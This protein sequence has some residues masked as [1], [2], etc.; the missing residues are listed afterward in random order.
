MQLCG[1]EERIPLVTGAQGSFE[2]IRP[3]I[4][5][6][7]FDG[8]EAVDFII[9][10]AMRDREHELI[11]LP[12]GKLTN[13]ALALLKEPRIAEKVRIVWLGS[14]YP[15]PGEHNQDWDIPSMNYILDVDVPFEMVTVRYGDPS[16]TDAVKVTQAQMLRRMPGKGPQAENPVTGRHGGTFSCWGDYSADL[17]SKYGM[18]GNPPARALFDLAAIA[19]VKNPAWAEHYE[20]PAPVFQDGQWAERPENLRK[21]VIWEWFDIYGIINDYFVTME[22]YV[23]ADRPAP[24]NQKD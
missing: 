6:P 2:E 19:I 3:F 21:I 10:Q 13:I 22:N 5:E 23:L 18:W 16:G 9:E 11:L 8:H 15:E 12:V 17:F 1:A 24:D 7:D 14:N 20:H 4:D